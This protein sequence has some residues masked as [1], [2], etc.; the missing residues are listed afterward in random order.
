[1]PEA[2]SAAHD[3]T[4][5]R[6][7]FRAFP[8]SGRVVPGSFQ[9]LVEDKLAV[10]G[11]PTVLFRC[12]PK[13]EDT[14]LICKRPVIRPEDGQKMERGCRSLHQN[15]ADSRKQLGKASAANSERTYLGQVGLRR[16]KQNTR[17]TVKGA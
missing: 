13:P 14:S 12:C 11:S 2:G 17:C 10:S 5:K 3:S 7:S 9:L 1:M 8:T 16:Q 15:S 4:R 6:C